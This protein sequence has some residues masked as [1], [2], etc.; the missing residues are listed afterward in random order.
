MKVLC[1]KKNAPNGFI[2]LGASTFGLVVQDIALLL[3]SSSHLWPYMENQTS[4]YHSISLLPIDMTDSVFLRNFYDGLETVNTIELD[5][6]DYCSVIALEATRDKEKACYSYNEVYIL[7]KIM[8][9]MDV[10][11]AA[12]ATLYALAK[13]KQS[14]KESSKIF[15]NPRMLVTARSRSSSRLS[16]IH[17]KAR[18]MRAAQVRYYLQNPYIKPHYVH[19]SSTT[20]GHIGKRASEKSYQAGPSSTQDELGGLRDPVAKPDKKTKSTQPTPEPLEELFSEDEPLDKFIE[21][22]KEIKL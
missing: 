7:L 17:A 9:H 8:H 15:P 19:I 2:I 1:R 3:T 21:A 14:K 22:I 12:L 10:Y 16:P 11:A 20:I 5:H 18:S 4:K 6:E 13:T